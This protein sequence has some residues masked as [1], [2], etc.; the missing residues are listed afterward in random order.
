MTEYQ[1]IKSKGIS[2]Y[3]Y[4]HLD[5]ENFKTLFKTASIIHNY[6]W[7]NLS[8]NKWEFHSEY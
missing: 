1:Y 7:I 2:T 4:D 6:W 5:V 8:Q 3:Y